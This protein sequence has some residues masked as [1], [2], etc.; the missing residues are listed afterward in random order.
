MRGAPRAIVS[1][2]ALTEVNANFQQ[3]WREAQPIAQVVVSGVPTLN[4]IQ[5]G[6]VVFNTEGKMYWR[7]GKDI[8][9]FTGVKV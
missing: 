8:Y 2:D 9:E 6:Q 3:L 7:N 4:S 5:D 1:S